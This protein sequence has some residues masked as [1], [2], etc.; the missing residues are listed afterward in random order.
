MIEYI[1]NLSIKQKGVISLLG[2]FLIHLTL[3][4]VFLWGNI[5]VYLRSYLYYNGKNYNIS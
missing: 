4:T 3:G 5:N 2:G 1:L